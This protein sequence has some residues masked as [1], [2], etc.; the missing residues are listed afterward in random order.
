MQPKARFFTDDSFI[1]GPFF[2]LLF[3][4]NWVQCIRDHRQA[5]LPARSG[6]GSIGDFCMCTPAN[7]GG[8]AV[9]HIMST[10]HVCDGGPQFSTSP[11]LFVVSKQ[12]F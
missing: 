11:A 2:L 12:V 3:F 8:K 1:M 10:L 7:F 6:K 9:C 4:C 5:A